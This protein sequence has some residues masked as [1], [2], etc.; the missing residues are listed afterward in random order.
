MTDDKKEH[1]TK[2]KLLSVSELLQNVSQ[3]Q[4]LTSMISNSFCNKQKRTF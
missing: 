3:W 2:L 4:L 1:K